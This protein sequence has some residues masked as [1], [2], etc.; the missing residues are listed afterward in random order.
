VE[1]CGRVARDPPAWYL[2]KQGV[3]RRGPISRRSF[4]NRTDYHPP[5]LSIRVGDGL[6]EQDIL[7]D[8]LVYYLD[9]ERDPSTR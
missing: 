6:S 5:E 1:R 9:S 4:S 2:D 8:I 7:S 3:H